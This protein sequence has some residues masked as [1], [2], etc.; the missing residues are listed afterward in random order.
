MKI[1]FLAL[2]D[3]T[4]ASSRTRVFQYLPHL[5][6]YNI[7]YKVLK[8]TKQNLTGKKLSSY[9][10]F[11]RL[12]LLLFCL[13]YDIVFI[14]KVLL[15]KNYLNIFK[16]LKKKIVFDFD[17]AIYTTHHSVE[18]S[19]K[20]SIKKKIKDRFQ[21]TVSIADL[22]ILENEYTKKYV[23]KFNANILMITGPI[24]TVRYFPRAQ[25][26]K[27]NIVIGWIGSPPNTMYL[28]PLYSVFERL[29]KE[30]PNVCFKTIGAAHI[31][32]HNVNIKQVD[33]S[34][35]TEVRELQ[36]FDI[37]IMPLFDDEWS[38]GKG[39]YKLLQYMAIGIPSVASPVGINV[40][41]IR[42]DINGYLAEEKE[43]WYEKLS[44]LINNAEK[45]ERLGLNARKIAEDK[46]SF[47]IAIK[48]LIKVLADLNKNWTAPLR[49]DR[50]G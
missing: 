43:D 17:D 39:G 37:G 14:Q 12:K 41:M 29:S 6:K 50:W 15:P 9:H 11:I 13:F 34:L 44:L 42:D 38:R 48:K 28:E 46:Y 45:R 10:A 23:E 22:I 49:L 33:W 31:E 4:V 21:E 2:G 20:H 35:D 24:D 32:L 36:E 5:K 26:N 40:E 8:Y 3:E 7:R 30:Y 1:L 27:E 25:R 19:T 47:F 18:N 16:F